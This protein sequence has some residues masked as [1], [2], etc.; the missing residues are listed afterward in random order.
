MKPPQLQQ[1]HFDSPT[2]KVVLSST[3]SSPAYKYP[4]LCKPSQ[5]TKL[6]QRIELNKHNSLSEL[7]SKP[8]RR[9]EKTY[10]KMC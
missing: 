4:L 2:P 1:G 9:A 3:S 8:E 5:V 7:Q 10:P 6:L